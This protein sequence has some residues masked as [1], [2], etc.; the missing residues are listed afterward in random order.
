WCSVFLLYP[1]VIKSTSTRL[2]LGSHYI[3]GY[4][5]FKSDANNGWNFAP[6]VDA[7]DF[8]AYFLGKPNGQHG[9]VPTAFTDGYMVQMYHLVNEAVRERLTDLVLDFNSKYQDNYSVAEKL[10]RHAKFLVTVYFKYGHNL[11]FLFE[12]YLDL[13][14]TVMHNVRKLSKS[15]VAEQTV[16][17][18]AD[19]NPI[20]KLHL[21]R[22]IVYVVDNLGNL[23]MEPTA[24]RIAGDILQGDEEFLIPRI[25]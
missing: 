10:Q 14:C 13:V 11:G 5:Y 1:I 3:R 24:I 23:L 9:Q 18:F 16:T 6:N 21:Y 20:I 8:A 22:E 19:Q 12:A 17:Q 7:D 2:F 4:D 15:V 25:F